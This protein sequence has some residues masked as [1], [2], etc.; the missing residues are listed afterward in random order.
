MKLFDF[1]AALL[2]V[3]LLG[4]Y[5]LWL[6]RRV[7]LTPLRTVIGHNAIKRRAWVQSVV[8]GRRDILAVQTL[9][10]WSMSASFLATTSILIATG[11]LHLLVSIPQQPDLLHAM[12][13]LGS[14]S[15]ALITI[16]LFVVVGTLLAAFFNFAFAI[17][18]FNHVSIEINV[19]PA[20]PQQEAGPVLQRMM[21]RGGMHYTIGMRCFYLVIPVA[22][23]LFGPTWLLL[24]SI[25]LTAALF[26][27]DRLD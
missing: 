21:D 7:R 8:A 3:L 24:G 18:Y 16:K 20:D 23:W 26:M 10:N 25:G 19:P 1:L 5:Y 4:F 17:R 13:F 6:A 15:S 11:A 27:M 12:N 9:R 2:S 14:T 22:L